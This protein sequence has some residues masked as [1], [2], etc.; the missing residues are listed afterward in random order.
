LKQALLE[1]ERL[2]QRVAREAIHLREL[3]FSYSAI[4]RRLEVDDKTVAK[5]IRWLRRM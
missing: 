2:Y 1:T 4:A 3:G 5:A